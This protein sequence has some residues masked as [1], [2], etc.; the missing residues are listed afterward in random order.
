[1]FKKYFV[2]SV[3]L[4]LIMNCGNEKQSATIEIDLLPNN[5]QAISVFGD[6]LFSGNPG[7]QALTKFKK[8]EQ[9]YKN[10]LQDS[11]ALIWYGR[12]MAYLGKYRE[13][14]NIYGMHLSCQAEY[15][16]IR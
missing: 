8:A 4:M 11:D 6:T 5:A 9:D 13:A 1:M 14:I 15:I 2:L 16:T 10:N 7:E 3:F 12:R